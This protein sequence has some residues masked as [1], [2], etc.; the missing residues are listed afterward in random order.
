MNA[1]CTA[2]TPCD[3]DSV[4][5][6]C[7]ANL[8]GRQPQ[9]G[10][11][12]MLLCAQDDS[13]DTAGES[14]QTQ[15]GGSS[16]E[17]SVVS[18]AQPVAALPPTAAEPQP[19]F[20]QRLHSVWVDIIDTSELKFG[21][22]LGEQ[23]TDLPVTNASKQAAQSN[24]SIRPVEL[25][26]S[27]SKDELESKACPLCPRAKLQPAEQTLCLSACIAAVWREFE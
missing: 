22:R 3:L 23:I 4:G 17:H 27:T 11:R 16:G 10:L 12:C 13:K 26:P 6:L 5:A 15:Y 19:G 1:P 21:R 9:P 2:D 7:F 24:P 8:L 18:P 14:T 25:S 20:D